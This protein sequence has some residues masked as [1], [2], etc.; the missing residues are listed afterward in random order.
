MFQRFNVTYIVLMSRI[1]EGYTSLKSYKREKKLKAVDPLP[2][3]KAGKLFMPTYLYV[4][5]FFY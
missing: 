5:P 3:L 2:P 4:T 1:R